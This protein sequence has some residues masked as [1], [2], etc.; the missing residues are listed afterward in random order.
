MREAAHRTLPSKEPARG[1]AAPFLLRVK[2][3]IKDTTLKRTREGG[4]ILVFVSLKKPV[5]GANKTREGCFE[6]TKEVCCPPFLLRV[7]LRVPF[8]APLTGSFEG[9]FLFA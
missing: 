3:K 2:S 7:F 4:S 1:A 5:R 9:I 8:A 6:G